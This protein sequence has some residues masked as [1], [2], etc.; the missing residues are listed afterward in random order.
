MPVR[1][2]LLVCL[3]L[4]LALVL[5]GLAP[6]FGWSAPFC[7]GLAALSAPLQW[8]LMHESIHNNL[9]RA[10]VINPWRAAP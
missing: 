3:G 7:L 9:A 2:V 5:F 10:P 4:S 6:A 1:N 8:A